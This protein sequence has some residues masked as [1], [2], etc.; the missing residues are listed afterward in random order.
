MS[1]ILRYLILIPLLLNLHAFSQ[2]QGKTKIQYSG[3]SWEFNKQIYEFGPRILGNVVMN[4]DSAFLYCDSAYVNEAENR[5]HAYGNV[6][7]KLSD[8]LNLYSD[9]LRYDGN[10]KIAN[11]YSNVRL[12][13]NQTTLT[14]DTLVYNRNTRIAQYDY[15][16]KIVNDK[17]NLVSHHGYYYTD[18]KEFFFKDR[19]IMISP[20]YNMYSD[21]LMYNT[22][23]ETSYFFGPSHIISKDKK[24]S[25]YCENGWYNTRVDI[26]RFRDRARIY[27]ETTYLT[28][29]SMYYE[30]KNGFGQVFRKALMVDTVQNIILMG[31]YGEMQRKNGFAYMTDS[32]VSVLVD[33]KDSL[34]MHADTVRATFDSAQ[35]IKKVFCF[36]KV[37]FFR[38]DLQGMCDS[39]R[40][41][42]RDS[43]MTMYHNPVIWSDSNQ[44]SADSI[45]LTM[46][47]GAADSLKLYGSAFI[48]SKDDTGSFNQIKGRVILAKFRENELYKIKVLGNAQ[49]IYYAREEDKSLIGINLAVSS[50]MLVFLEKNQLK[51]IT[52]IDSPEAHLMPEKSVPLNERKLKNFRWEEKRRPLQKSDIFIW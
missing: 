33:K 35:N 48:I 49:T 44:L 30:R 25:I 3:D 23:T 37:K 47:N 13:D 29:D 28:G 8:T 40:Y 36:Y 52:Y 9:S 39:L 31:N 7:I 24:D 22:V 14:T 27:H 45:T 43:S 32:A 50:D 11:A 4:H 38:H 20:E 5:V 1:K 12:I 2:D 15:W 34:F 26:A 51:S 10:T 18:K 21:T 41:Q 17:N 42:G 16:G 6:R 46:L 19:V